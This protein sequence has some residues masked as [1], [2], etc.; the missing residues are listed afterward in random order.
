M[1]FPASQL[2]ILAYNRVVQDLNGRSAG[3]FLG[4]LASN[5]QLEST[6]QPLPETAGTCCVYL[7]GQWHKLTFP[8][9]Q[10]ETND[11]INSLDVAL[12]A[13]NGNDPERYPQDSFERMGPMDEELHLH[14]LYLHDE[15]QSVAHAFDAVCTPD[16]FG[17]NAGLGLQYRGRLDASRAAPAPDDLPRDLYEA[18]KQVAQTGQGPE[19]QIPSM[20]CSIKWKQAG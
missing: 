2:Q 13:V 12:L 4:E 18:M 6:V 14:G 5:F 8:S 7:D 19:Q 1:L 17:F 11:P 9:A 3:D 10:I 16:F 20:G 15:D